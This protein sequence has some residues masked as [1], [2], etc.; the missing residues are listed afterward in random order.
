MAAVDGERDCLCFGRWRGGLAPTA[1]CSKRAP[2]LMVRRRVVSTA[3]T[4]P[5]GRKSDSNV[6]A[7]RYGNKDPIFARTLSYSGVHGSGISSATGLRVCRRVTAHRQGK[8][9]GARTSTVPYSEANRRARTSLS[10][11]CTDN[12]NTPAAGGNVPP[13]GPE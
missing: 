13:P 3:G 4:S 12:E 1:C 9:R 11:R 2:T 7:R 5:I 6:R 10:G 8:N